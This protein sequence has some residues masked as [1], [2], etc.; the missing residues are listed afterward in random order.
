MK[1]FNAILFITVGLIFPLSANEP[2]ARVI[3]HDQLKTF[4]YKDNW[5]KGVATPSLGAQ[6]FE[7]WYTSWP[8]GWSTGPHSHES[9]EIFIFLKGKGKVI[10]EGEEL[11]FEAPC[12]LILPPHKTHEVFNIGDEPTEEIAIVRPGSNIYNE[13][14]KEIFLPWRK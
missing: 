11:F 5:A 9:E 6:E 13:E 10:S 8:V 3:P 1:F 14:G 2:K 12:T 4:S 7:V